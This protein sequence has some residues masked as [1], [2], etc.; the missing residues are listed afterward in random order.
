M[1]GVVQTPKQMGQEE[2]RGDHVLLVLAGEDNDG[3][4]S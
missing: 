1:D 2:D 4:R 3:M